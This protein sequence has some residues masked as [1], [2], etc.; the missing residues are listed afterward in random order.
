MHAVRRAFDVNEVESC[1]HAPG[2][3]P[4]SPTDGNHCKRTG[5]HKKPS[6]CHSSGTTLRQGTNLPGVVCERGCQRSHALH[7]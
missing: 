3:V 5:L 2:Y 1:S 4:K 6:V 7:S